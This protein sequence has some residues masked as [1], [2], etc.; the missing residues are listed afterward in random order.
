MWIFNPP[1]GSIY[2]GVG[3]AVFAS[4]KRRILCR[5]AAGD[6]CNILPTFFVNDG[7][8]N[9]CVF[10]KADSRGNRHVKIE[11]TFLYFMTA[12]NRGLLKEIL[13]TNSIKI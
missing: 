11:I 6:K 13:R 3:K 8:G 9:I 7:R 12:F 2:G 5:D 1:Y 4:S 10:S